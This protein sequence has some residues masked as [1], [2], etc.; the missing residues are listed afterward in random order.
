MHQHYNPHSLR[1]TRQSCR[2]ADAKWVLRRS[3]APDLTSSL[4]NTSRQ[5]AATAMQKSR[6]GTRSVTPVMSEIKPISPKRNHSVRLNKCRLEH[7]DEGDI[8]RRSTL[9][10]FYSPHHRQVTASVSCTS[11]SGEPVQVQPLKLVPLGAGTACSNGGT[12]QSPSE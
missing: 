9:G 12:Q 5:R 3:W 8:T 6:A 11:L 4:L 7:Y 10:L 1:K 2:S